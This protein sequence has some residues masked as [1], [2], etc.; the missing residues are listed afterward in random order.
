MNKRDFLKSMAAAGFS[1]AMPR[2]L[3]ADQLF[4][5][6]LAS[7]MSVEARYYDVLI[8]RDVIKCMLCPHACALKNGQSGMC[9]TRYSNG[10]KLMTKAYGNPVAVHVDP[11]EKKPLHHFLP[12]AKVYSL[13]T[14]GCNLRCL[15]CQN[16]EISQVSPDVIP[17]FEMSPEQV[18]SNALELKSD[19]IAFTYTE[20]TVFFEYM[21]DTAKLARQA[22]L[23]TIVISNGY[24][25]PD[26]LSELISVT[27]AFNIDLKAFSAK[28]YSELCG[29]KAEP[30]KNT[31]KQIRD[32]KAWLEIT[33]LLVSGYSDN[34]EEYFKLTEWLVNNDFLGTPLHIS[35]FFPAYRLKDSLP[36][37]LKIMEQ[38]WKTANEA[39]L[40]YVYTGNLRDGAHENTIC[41]S[42]GTLLVSRSGYQTAVENLNDG[43]CSQCGLNIPGVWNK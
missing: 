8:D 3:Q 13:G 27:D 14:A 21:I 31:L 32:S 40:K 29:A 10:S 15:N 20:P 26:P 4:N 28:V 25:L 37:D 41:P 33:T 18:V 35:R 11:V 1:A 5:H 16:S 22:G 43:K 6:Q 2:S 24:I 7:A 39:G 34:M 19:G 12:G 38:A 42:C 36:T 9:K 17:S 30:V 23:K